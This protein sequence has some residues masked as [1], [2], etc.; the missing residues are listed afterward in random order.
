MR[1][2]SERN[3][4]SVVEGHLNEHRA[5]AR[6]VDRKEGVD[7]LRSEGFGIEAVLWGKPNQRHLGCAGLADE[8]DEEK[9][10]E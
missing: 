8:D 3:A 9:G 10:G 1:P 6:V 2:V 5:L 7:A 4:E